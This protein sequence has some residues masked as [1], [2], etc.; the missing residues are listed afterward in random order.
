MIGVAD[1]QDSSV[2]ARHGPS[3]YPATLVAAVD[4]QSVTPVMRELASAPA[5]VLIDLLAYL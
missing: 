5:D 2:V 3:V 1:D 4:Q